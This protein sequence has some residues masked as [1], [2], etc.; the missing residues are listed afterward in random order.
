[1]K[2]KNKILKA[3]TGAQAD[4]KEGKAMSPGT[5]ATGGTRGGGRDPSAQFDGPQSLSIKNKKALDAQRKAARSVISPSTTY[6]NKAIALAAGLVVPG[7]GFLYK[8]AID[9]N[10]PFAPKR[11]KQKPIT[12]DNMNRGNGDSSSG[13]PI[14]PNKPIDPLLIKPKD[15]FFNFKAYNSGGVSS[16]PPPKRGPNPQVPPIKMKKGK[17]NSMTCPHRP[18]GIR[19]MGAAIKGFKFIGVK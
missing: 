12:T 13:V 5:G 4:T 2:R 9:A 10:T 16:G 14:T 6:V 11:K 3:F 19:G 8:R 7:G 15:N 17:M 1:M 18:D